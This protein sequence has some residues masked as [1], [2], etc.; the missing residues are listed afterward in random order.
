MLASATAIA[1]AFHPA[2][3]L[4]WML[5]GYITIGVLEA[6]LDISRRLAGK[7]SRLVDG[8]AEDKPVEARSKDA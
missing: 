7:P 6:V 1:I 5:A 2:F 4:V 3:A 8:A